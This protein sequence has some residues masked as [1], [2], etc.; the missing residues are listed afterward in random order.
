MKPV[1]VVAIVHAFTFC[2]DVSIGKI[3]VIAF[4]H[5]IFTIAVGCWVVQ[6]E[7][8]CRVNLLHIVWEIVKPSFQGFT[9]V[10]DSFAGEDTE[11]RALTGVEVLFDED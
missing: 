2:V 10:A 3:P 5:V 1:T 11:R 6:L 8:R 9:Q 4:T 7:F